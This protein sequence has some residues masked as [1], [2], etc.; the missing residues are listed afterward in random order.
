M[1]AKDCITGET[2]VIHEPDNA[3]RL[4]ISRFSGDHEE[5]Y[6]RF[7]NSYY[8]TNM[9]SGQWEF[10]MS[11]PSYSGRVIRKATKQEKLWLDMCI[12][13]NCFVERP[14]ALKPPIE[15]YQIY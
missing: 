9:N 14:E 10:S 8:I 6:T 5:G 2:Y 13:A 3:S 11:T 4:I 7:M 1:N 12:L 15:N